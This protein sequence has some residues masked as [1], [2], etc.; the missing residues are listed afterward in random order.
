MKRIGAVLAMF[1]LAGTALAS[2]N[3]PVVDQ[4]AAANAPAVRGARI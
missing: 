1:V 3:T 2:A 4:R